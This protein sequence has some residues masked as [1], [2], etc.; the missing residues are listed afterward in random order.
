MSEQAEVNNNNDLEKASVSDVQP[1]SYRVDSGREP[2]H[3]ATT[4]ELPQSRWHRFVDTFR[5]DESQSVTP[6]GAIGADGK[7]Y[8]PKNVAL[9]T[10]NSP[11]QRNLKARHLQMIAIGGSI[12]EIHSL[13]PTGRSL[14][15]VRNWSLH[16]LR[17]GSQYWW[18]RLA[19]HI[20]QSYWHYA[21]LYNPGSW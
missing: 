1:P 17:K 19:R 21:L 18:P 3:G 5:R 15:H 13:L 8:D 20:F 16:C 2:N 14:T 6:K 12:G 4:E 7:V 9:A 10:A 11:L